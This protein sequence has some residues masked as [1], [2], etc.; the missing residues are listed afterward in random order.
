MLHIYVI[1]TLKIL[2]D[3][4][5]EKNYENK[6]NKII[7]MLSSLLFEI[8]KKYFS[9]GFILMDNIKTVRL[10]PMFAYFICSNYMLAYR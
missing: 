6:P 1:F 2:N 10:S 9:D 3:P 7:I 4:D 5:L 8:P